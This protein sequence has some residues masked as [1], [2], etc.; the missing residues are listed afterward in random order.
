[1]PSKTSW[2]NKEIIIQDFRSVGWI[3]LFFSIGL[4][5]TIPV[6]LLLIFSNEQRQYDR[7]FTNHITDLFDVNMP[8]QMILFYVIP[9]LLA[10]F[11]FRYLHVKQQTDMV[12]SFPIRRERL[13]FHHIMSGL[14][15]LLIPILLNAVIVLLLLA[16]LD[17]Q[18]YISYQEV[19][20]WV[21]AAFL[22]ESLMFFAGVLIAMVTGISA[23]QGILTYIMLFFPYGF[24]MLAIMNI[25]N[26]FYGYPANYLIVEEIFYYSPITRLPFIS[27]KPLSVLEVTI[28]LIL[29]VGFCITSL[30]LYKRRNLE[31]ASQAIAFPQLKPIF[32][33]GVTFCFM[34]LGGI[35]FGVVEQSER[36]FWLYFGY[37]TFSIIGYFIAEMI[38][39]KTW[40]VFSAIKGY[41]FYALIMSVVLL[42]LHFDVTGYEK[43]MP[44]LSEVERVYFSP[45]IYTAD[46]ES[47]EEEYNQNAY[48]DRKNIE[49]I[50]HIHK[51]IVD[52]KQQAKNGYHFNEVNF[53]Y[54]LKNGKKFSRQYMIKDKDA[55]KDLYNVI[56]SSE[57]YKE[58]YFDILQVNAEKVDKITI[59]SHYYKSKN[60]YITKPEEIKEAIS[61]LQDEAQ[62]ADYDIL[63]DQR[64][65]W[66]NIRLTLS[67]GKTVRETWYKGY[68]QFE[69][70]LKEKEHLNEVR[71]TSDDVSKVFVAK[72]K[73]L[74]SIEETD[75]SYE[76]YFNRADEYD[77]IITI[78]DKAQIEEA[79]HN[80]TWLGDGEYIVGF[81]YEEDDF[82]D[83][84]SFSE[85]YV[86]QFVKEKLAD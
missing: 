26:W 66:G 17:I 24:S 38:L 75:Y 76:E 1:M 6:Q 83:I 8:L 43:K 78:T 61:I 57:E 16:P 5:F 73:D 63:N 22:M 45:Y 74:Q 46:S 25:K 72:E 4:F 69:H 59:E 37:A 3:S 77:F 52:E 49:A 48:E 53:I 23:V 84:K 55:L 35:Y 62:N 18:G 80:A 33:Y 71:M 65:P 42:A 60:S 32:K 9:V 70:W 13:Y 50:Y 51:S 12:H 27:E 29:T 82:I 15:F 56:Y 41:L 28:Y 47:K 34:L 7:Y 14:F 20:E 19:F 86:P 2:F 79:I 36:T 67:N 30:L 31:A 64:E 68:E 40:R 58:K 54:E 11:L 85:K 39:Q 21:G 81:Y 44:E 10:I